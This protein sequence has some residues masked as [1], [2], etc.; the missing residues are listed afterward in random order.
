MEDIEYA[1]ANLRRKEFMENSHCRAKK[2]DVSKPLP[3]DRAAQGAAA[4]ACL[5]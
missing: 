3:Q 5:T 1:V 4:P 2:T